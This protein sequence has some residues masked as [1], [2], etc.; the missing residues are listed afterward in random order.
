MKRKKTRS[1][2][3]KKIILIAILA[4]LCVL[5]VIIFRGGFSLSGIGSALSGNN[6][7][8]IFYENAGTSVFTELDGG[9]AR[10]GSAGLDYI[11]RDGNITKIIGFSTN[12]PV[13]SSMG[14][15]GVLYDVGGKRMCV[16][17]SDGVIKELESKVAVISA[18]LNERGWLAVCEQENGYNGAVR[19]Y[20]DE[21]SLVYEW[22]SGSGY[23]ISA[24][25]SPNSKTLAVLTATK[26]GSEIVFLPLNDTEE[27]GRY[28]A[29]DTLFVDIAFMD[30]KHVA[31]ISS[32]EWIL[33]DTHG[34]LKQTHT[35]EN[36]Y[37]TGFAMKNGSTTAIILNDYQVE[38]QSE[39]LA[40][41]PGGRISG[42]LL[43][44]RTVN[45]V[46]VNGRHVSVLYDDGAATY[47]GSLR[48]KKTSSD[49]E[50]DEILTA[51]NGKAFLVGTYSAKSLG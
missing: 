10:A 35:F 50:A 13:L 31:A 23:V 7:D 6:S 26:S 44:E 8:E 46:S 14:D 19:V 43:T 36:K 1:S 24:A 11:D 42:T 30:N 22:Y 25:L 18:S 5:A 9:L 41:S 29:D 28:R 17:E 12:R 32:N 51:K 39:I 33:T 49:T 37:L 27:K 48:E 21:G 40:I 34:N 38:T 45:D 4:V 15:R 2:G 16:F 20:N 3:L 47:S